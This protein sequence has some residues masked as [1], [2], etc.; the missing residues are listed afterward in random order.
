MPCFNLEMIETRADF[1]LRAVDQVYRRQS[2]W[3]NPTTNYFNSSADS[4]IVTVFLWNVLP[5]TKLW[6]LAHSLFPLNITVLGQPFPI[7]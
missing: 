2:I 5:N 6:D 3:S 7:S 4:V 1:G